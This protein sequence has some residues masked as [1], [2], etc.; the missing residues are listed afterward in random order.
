MPS[1][2]SEHTRTS[3]LEKF[4]QA[5]DANDLQDAS[6]PLLCRTYEDD[7]HEWPKPAREAGT[8]LLE[9]RRPLFHLMNC[10]KEYS[11]RL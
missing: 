2:H 7:T 5:Y 1:R 4:A 6:A 3:I 11:A 9:I 8:A 10:D